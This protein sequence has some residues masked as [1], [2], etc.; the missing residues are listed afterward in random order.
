[1]TTSTQGA[2]SSGV[3]GALK[4]SLS[5]GTFFMTNYTAVNQ[6]GSVSFA[7]HLPGQ[8]FPVDVAPQ[9]GYGYMA[10]RRA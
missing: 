1:M 5:G 8:I 7:A 6:P 2:G 10:H 3:F 9:P 4:R